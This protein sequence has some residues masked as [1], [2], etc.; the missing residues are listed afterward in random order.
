MPTLCP[1]SVDLSR[2][3]STGRVHRSPHSLAK[4][5]PKREARGSGDKPIPTF[6]LT[7]EI[8]QSNQ[9]AERLIKINYEIPT[10]RGSAGRYGFGLRAMAQVVSFDTRSVREAA[11]S[12]ARELGYP[13]L[14]PEQL[15]VIETFAKGRDVFAVLPTGYGKSLCYGCLP[16]VFDKLLGT[17]GEGSSIVVV[18]SPLTAIMK[19][20]VSAVSMNECLVI[21]VLQ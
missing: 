4:P 1:C 3:V 20:Q 10:P 12:A 2:V 19:D 9:I 6:V 15:K 17:G 18:V 21:A 11:R 5:D 7:A 8:L 16:I 13:D 14:K